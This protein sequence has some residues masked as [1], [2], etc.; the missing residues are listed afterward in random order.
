MAAQWFVDLTKLRKWLEASFSETELR[1]LCFDL[2][3]D[4]ENLPGEEKARKC[5]ELVSYMGRHGRIQEVVDWCSQERPDFSPVDVAGSAMFT[6]RSGVLSGG[7]AGGQVGPTVGIIAALPIEYDAVR[8]MMENGKGG[9]G[10]SR[11]GG[12]G[13]YLGEIP[14]AGDE[15]HGVV[16]SRLS[17]GVDNAAAACAADLIRVFPS[18]SILILVGIASS[19]LSRTAS[20]RHVQH[21]DI[22][23][24]GEQAGDQISS[25]R[26]PYRPSP[27]L[28]KVSR[29]IEAKLTAKIV[30][31]T[32]LVERAH[33]ILDSEFFRFQRNPKGGFDII[34]Y[35]KNESTRTIIG[36]PEVFTGSSVS[37]NAFKSCPYKPNG[38]DRR[39]SGKALGERDLEISDM[40]QMGPIENLKIYGVC[41]NCVSCDNDTWFNYAA[42]VSAAYTRVLLESIP[43]Q[44]VRPVTYTPVLPQPKLDRNEQ[45][46][47]LFKAMTTV[48][49]LSGDLH[50]DSRDLSYFKCIHDL[51]QDLRFHY[52]GS[53]SPDW[54]RTGSE[55]TEPVK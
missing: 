5:L 43:V 19:M 9:P 45:S 55:K 15:M 46:A 12:P 44:P 16:L 7:F 23:V 50:A 13:Y 3:V 39:A 32:R 49:A 4:Y 8:A 48:E 18:V 41:G 40:A 26:F 10:A 14:S 29:D 53:T 11:M 30:Q 21:G 24:P 33:D 37:V 31:W 22:I 20:G 35:S 51:L 38:S 17:G 36:L 2:R 52:E 47:E 25:S 54:F 28:L 6:Q 27:K 34:Y 1:T 42:V